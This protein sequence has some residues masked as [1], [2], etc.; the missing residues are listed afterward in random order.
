M[1]VLINIYGE[2][3][4]EAYN[5]EIITGECEHSKQQL[6]RTRDRNNCL[7]AYCTCN[8]WSNRLKGALKKYVNVNYNLFFLE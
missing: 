7:I 8:I 3:I 1:H 5:I 4:E 6:E 2:E